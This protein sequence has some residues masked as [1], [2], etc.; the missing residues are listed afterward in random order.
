MVFTKINVLIKLHSLIWK[1][2]VVG[3]AVIECLLSWCTK[4]V[5]ISLTQTRNQSFYPVCFPALYRDSH[6]IK[7][8]WT[9]GQGSLA[10]T[11]FYEATRQ[12]R[13]NDTTLP[14]RHVTSCLNYVFRTG[15]VN[16]INDQP[17][18][19]FFFLIVVITKEYVWTETQGISYRIFNK[20]NV[21]TYIIA[22][23][24]QDIVVTTVIS[25]LSVIRHNV[26]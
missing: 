3:V 5:C 12:R 20:T 24:E 9:V 26:I 17:V 8:Y 4:I 18:E 13:C 14:P 23:A 15:G 16:C 19:L 11:G 25:W 1:K 7:N 22:K 6:D 21:Q 2:N 10:G